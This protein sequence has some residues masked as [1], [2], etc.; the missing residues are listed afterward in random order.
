MDGK[1]KPFP[2]AQTA[3]GERTGQFSPDGQW[4]AFESNQSGRYDIHLQQFPD[5]TTTTVISTGG[6][7]QPR[8]GPDGQELFYIAPDGRLMA[9]PLQFSSGR[10]VQPS[11]PVPLF[12]ARVGSTLTGGSGVEYIVA[13]KGSGF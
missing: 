13:D 7:L 4:V 6:G 9:V 2:V 3:F 12:A 5:P 1:G 11:P 10:T 8:W